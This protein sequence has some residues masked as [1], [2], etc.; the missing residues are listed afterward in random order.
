MSDNW[1][2]LIPTDPEYMPDATS[3]EKARELFASLV[4]DADEVDVYVT[5]G[6]RFVDQ[7]ENFSSVSCPKCGT[8]LDVGWWNLA[9]TKACGVDAEIDRW[10]FGFETDL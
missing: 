6:V 9:M 8:K 10:D 7:G 5:D 2:I 1:L 3:Q 4:S